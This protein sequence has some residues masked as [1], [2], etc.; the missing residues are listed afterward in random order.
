MT[1]ALPKTFFPLLLKSFEGEIYQKEV[2]ASFF[3]PTYVDKKEKSEEE[4]EESSFVSLSIIFLQISILI[5][6][7]CYENLDNVKLQLLEN[8]S[9]VCAIKNIILKEIKNYKDRI[10]DFTL[11]LLISDSLEKIEKPQKEAEK[12]VCLTQK[13][14]S[15]KIKS[16]Y[17]MKEQYLEHFSTYLATFMYLY[18]N[19]LHIGRC[20]RWVRKEYMKS[21][22]GKD[23]KDNFDVQMISSLFQ[24][25][26]LNNCSNFNQ[27]QMFDES[28]S[29]DAVEDQMIS[30]FLSLSSPF[31]ALYQSQ[32]LN[33]KNTEE[34]TWEFEEE[35]Q[36][37]SKTI[38]KVNDLNNEP[39]EIVT[40]PIKDKKESK[41]W[42][43]KLILQHMIRYNINFSTISFKSISQNTE[44]KQESKYSLHYDIAS[45]IPLRLHFSL[46]PMV[47]IVENSHLSDQ[48]NANKAT[49]NIEIIYNADNENVNK[50]RI[51][52]QNVNK[53][54]SKGRKKGKDSKIPNKTKIKDQQKVKGLDNEKAS[55]TNDIPT[56]DNT[57]GVTLKKKDSQG[58]EL[59]TYINDFI[60]PSTC[61]LVLS[62]INLTRCKLDDPFLFHS[63]Q[64]LRLSCCNLKVYDL[65]PGLDNSS[66]VDSDNFKFSSSITLFGCCNL[67]LLDLSYNENLLAVEDDYKISSDSEDI[68]SQ[69][70]NS[71][72]EEEMSTDMKLESKG[73]NM[74]STNEGSPSCMKSNVVDLFFISLLA[75][76]L[77][78]LNLDGCRVQIHQLH[79]FAKLY[80]SGHF[81]YPKP[82]PFATFSSNPK[83]KTHTFKHLSL[84]ENKI[85]SFESFI[86]LFSTNLPLSSPVSTYGSYLE[87]LDLR[88]NPFQ[89]GMNQRQYKAKLHQLFPSLKMLDSYATQS[90][91]SVS[92]Q[93]TQYNI[94]KNN[95]FQ[96]A[97]EKEFDQA[98]TGKVDTSIVH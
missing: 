31:F 89:G 4:E 2:I 27:F 69:D 81:D 43:Q 36:D 60:L 93:S 56:N 28:M 90:D 24:T 10:A 18:V 75:T 33:S 70:E 82:S 22:G 49:S 39:T 3:N 17:T 30:S 97:N 74:K 54:I 68:D 59:L 64:E 52:S 37:E 45:S 35:I 53:E 9:S 72:N 46:P 8:N 91:F 1:N 57:D 83:K 48:H 86:E 95:D 67:E 50:E 73:I 21:V 65:L 20:S 71:S 66:Q 92:T 44:K 98:L 63:L 23:G 5:L 41:Q 19:Y 88:D 62:N 96:I 58:L 11:S 47:S 6:G 61:R 42:L 38:K 7:I 32:K 84:A 94:E 13:E 16:L 76:R 78:S 14:S 12:M 51:S 34:I 85:K 40:N 79:P 25:L 26:P 55:K 80:T 15:E 77:S 29:S 87:E